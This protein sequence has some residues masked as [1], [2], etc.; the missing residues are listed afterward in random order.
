MS[1]SLFVSILPHQTYWLYK[2]IGQPA[3]FPFNRPWNWLCQLQYYYHSGMKAQRGHW[4]GFFPPLSYSD[5]LALW[6]WTNPSL[7][8]PLG[9]FLS[10]LNWTKWNLTLWKFS[11]RAFFSRPAEVKSDIWRPG[12]VGELQRKKAREK[13]VI[14][15]NKMGAGFSISSLYQT[16]GVENRKKRVEHERGYGGPWRGY[17]PA[18]VS[19]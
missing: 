1:L 17:G 13:S 11:T 4:G 12:A 16:D 9:H 18:S 19:L 8:P 7:L 14:L 2:V 10:S 5:P 15:I 6:W 3:I